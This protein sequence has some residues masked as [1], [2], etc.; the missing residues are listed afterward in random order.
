MKKRHA[1]LLASF[2]TAG[3][4]AAGIPAYHFSSIE[5][6]QALAPD[7]VD[8]DTPAVGTA[9]DLLLVADDEPQYD[10][11][12]VILHYTA[13]VA[14]ESLRFYIWASGIS[15]VE[16]EAD[17]ISAD[18]KS[19]MITLDF[20]EDARF[21]R[22]AGLDGMSFIIKTAGTWQGQ[23]EDTYLDYSLFPPVDT[24]VEVWS[25]P[26]EGNS[27]E[28]YATEEETKMDKI[29][30]AQFSNWQEITVKSTIEPSSWALY[31]FTASYLKSDGLIQKNTKANY[32]LK[33]GTELKDVQ[34]VNGGVSFKIPLRYLVHPNIR[35]V[36][37]A[38][39]PTKPDK[40]MSK[41]IGFELLYNTERFEKYYTYKG[42]D[43]GAI[44]NDTST[45]FKV[46]AP[47]ATKMLLYLYMKG[48]PAN[49][50]DASGQPGS[51]N[52]FE[53]QMSYQEGGVWTYTHKSK[54]YGYYYTYFVTGQ[55]GN[56]EVVD[57]YAK[58]CGINGVRG[59][60][61]DWSETNP[62]GWE[63]IPEVWD[64]AEG[65]DIE[66]RNE[67]SVYEVHVRD[68]TEDE[69]WIG[70]SKRGT[71]SAF[72]EKGTTFTK[73]E[74]TVKTGFDHIEE[75]GVKAVQLLPVFD[76]DNDETDPDDYNWGYNPLNYNCVE[77]AY[78]TNPYDA[79]AR[80]IE[81]KSLI[82]DYASN[83]NHTR[84]IMD[85]VYN[86]VS[87][88]P[89]SN[90]AK[91]MPRYY[92]RHAA[93]WSYYNGSG[94]GNE[95][96]S[97]APM[98]R[99]FII[100]SLCFWAS[101]YKIKGF[102]FDLMGLIDCET[103]KQAATALY[104]IDPDIVMYGEGWRGDGDSFHGQGIAAET[105][106][107]YSELYGTESRVPVGAF[108][109][110][111]RNAL[112]G[113]NDAGWGSTSALPGKGYMQN[114]SVSGDD[115]G[116]ISDMILG[117]HKGQ[118]GNPEQ[119]VNYA[120]CH[121]NWTLFDQ[122][123]LTYGDS[124]EPS[125]TRVADA[126]VAALSVIMVSNGIAFIQGG[127]EFF[128]SKVLNAEDIEEVESTTYESKYGKY[129]SHNS[130]NSPAHVNS[131]KWD[132]KISVG[133]VDTSAYYE[134]IVEAVKLHTSLPKFTYGHVPHSGQTTSGGNIVGN[135][136][137]AGN[138]KANNTYNG[139]C[140]FQLDEYFIFLAGANWGYISF[141]DVPQ[142]ELVF[143]SGSY[144]YDNNNGTVNVGNYD[145]NTGGSIAIF[146]RNK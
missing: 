58:A 60:V 109:D 78:S 24:V 44:T 125:F 90:F 128:R 146:K 121:D 74:K 10:V 92:F 20:V 83:A 7:V 21:K 104:Q 129:Y 138:N 11:T 89:G 52:R 71:Y 5:H 25:I 16:Y 105:G 28:I 136:Y 82:R 4:I 17:S 132:R 64:G 131:F 96:R 54:M 18:G 102:R 51:N 32:L 103:L 3:V 12:K 47:T 107:A 53:I 124:V 133:D 143:S 116:A 127:D 29:V 6:Q 45:T 85:V 9:K 93:D 101:E 35:Y 98:M 37:E 97:E 76:H 126:S 110:T 100:D 8:Y 49:L 84:V 42:D 48:T 31:A 88:A 40:N 69:T 39:F 33:S 91:L 13:D 61:V 111:G 141:G 15:G 62:E 19:M 108:N 120:S 142:S 23:S 57:P 95:V 73:D 72:A 94:C 79:T 86:H 106:K 50:L 46:W 81:Y 135:T 123:N 59:A 75:L 1:L 22:F 113:G 27:I 137:W 26:G 99:K 36:L 38:V 55:N 115:A 139:A 118:G 134:K 65:Y 87:S 112:R 145:A 130:Y 70:E 67:L 114:S 66:S 68:L 122:L 30:T 144:E 119:C 80:I 43:L 41:N 117:Y 14:V 56:Y 140:G 77:G 63:E 2:L 34:Q